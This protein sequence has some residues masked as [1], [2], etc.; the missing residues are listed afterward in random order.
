VG[1]WGHG[2]LDSDYALDELSSRTTELVE[3]LMDRA[4]TAESR[5]A[6]EW[7]YTTLFVELEIVFA[8]E[9]ANLM[10][11]ARLPLA[12][13]VRELAADYI[14]DWDE[15][16]VELDPTANHESERRRIIL[17]SFER[18]AVICEK[19]ARPPAPAR[20]TAKPKAKATKPK[21]KAT[22]PKPK[23]KR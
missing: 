10:H 3:G 4:R 16:I 5:E 15:Y 9:A 22:T 20:P 1:T 2:N 12:T 8:L 19:H 21:A 23:A 17:E 6:D 13:E 11:A 18:F 14:A 7:D